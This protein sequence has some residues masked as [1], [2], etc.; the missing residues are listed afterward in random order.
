MYP[1]PKALHSSQQPAALL[2]ILRSSRKTDQDQGKAAPIPGK[3]ENACVALPF[4][5]KIVQGNQ[6]F[7]YTTLGQDDINGRPAPLQA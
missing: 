1:L 3:T 2:R 6:G 4:R 7:L 5:M